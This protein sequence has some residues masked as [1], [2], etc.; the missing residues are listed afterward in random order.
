MNLL[1]FHMRKYIGFDVVTKAT[2]CIIIF[3]NCSMCSIYRLRTVGCLPCG[4]SWHSLTALSN[5]RLF[6]YGGFDP[7]NVPLSKYLYNQFDN[8]KLKHEIL[9]TFMVSERLL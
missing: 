4:R 5:Q 1:N 7:N 3:G 9:Q 8:K 2:C 6:L